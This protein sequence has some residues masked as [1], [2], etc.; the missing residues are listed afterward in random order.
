MLL[1]G[2]FIIAGVALLAL[3]LGIE[4]ARRTAVKITEPLHELTEASD[5]L[6][7]G[8]RGARVTIRSG[9]ELE[10]LGQSFNQ[11]AAD[12]ESSYSELEARNEELRVEVEERKLAQAERGELQGHLIQ[13]QK[14]EAFGQLAGGVAHDFNN[15]L[16]VVMGNAELVEF[17]IED[18]DFDQVVEINQQIAQAAHRGANLTRQLLTFARREAG[19]PRILDVTKTLR[20]FE[21]LIRRVL[22]ESVDL[23]FELNTGVPPVLIDPGRLEQVLMN[24]CVNARDAMPAGGRLTVRTSRTVL[25]S[26][27]QV[28]SGILSP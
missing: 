28:R 16:A 14:M 3:I 17:H 8:D 1:T 4:V 23:R 2:L 5:R 21:K 22:E 6:A 20:D 12:L 15:I 18:G 7:S 10:I 9:D 25:Q 27:K 11:M 19:H 26:P 13:A 24:L